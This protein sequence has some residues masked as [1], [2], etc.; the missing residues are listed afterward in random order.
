MRLP[1]AAAGAAV[2][3]A[4]AIAI[5]ASSAWRC[6]GPASGAI[7]RPFRRWAICWRRRTRMFV[8]WLP[9]RSA[10]SEM[11]APFRRCSRRAARPLDRVGEHA[12]MHALIEIGDAA[13]TRAGL[14][15]AALGTR[16]AALVALDQMRGDALAST[17]VVPLLDARESG[18]ARRPG[19]L[20]SAIP[21]GARRSRATS[22]AAWRTC[23]LVAR[24]GRSSSAAWPSSAPRRP[25]RRGWREPR[26]TA[27]PG[28]GHSC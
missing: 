8:A 5:L 10:G 15:A 21:T 23:R 2:R 19:G 9:R 27:T 6:M 14:T 26:R 7:A 1:L 28:H 22:A 3:P 17:T 13:T 20:P 18:C 12:V 11:R 25:F 4:C 16:R 24:S